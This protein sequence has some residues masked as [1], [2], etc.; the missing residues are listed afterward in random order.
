MSRLRFNYLCHV[1]ERCDNPRPALAPSALP[2]PLLS[3]RARRW[4]DVRI[5]LHHFSN[6]DAMLAVEDHL[7]CMHVA[8]TVHLSQS[9]AGRTV[10]KQVSPGYVT[11]APRGEP[12]RLKHAGESAVIFVRLN[13][14]Y[15]ARVAGRADCVVDPARCAL[16]DNCGNR[17]PIA[18][19]IGK[20]M[21]AALELE[22]V[23]GRLRIDALKGELALHLLSHYSAS[24]PPAERTEARLSPRKLA[25]AAEYIDAHLRE[26]LSLACL[27][28]TLAMSP[29]HLSHA[30]RT[31]TGLPPH[32]FVL[33]RRVERAKHLL[34]HTDLSITDIAHRIGCAS[35]SHFSV[36]FRRSTGQTP[37]DFRR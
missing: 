16:I 24:S 22:D 29:S 19:D 35:H 1:V 14:A 8:G 26:D 23:V 30:F 17:D 33:Q 20:R 36:L 12:K 32:R 6:L 15:V 25:R 2:P 5:E 37:R 34:R 27:A 13:P 4:D 31:A 21:L 3:S 28:R 10:V 7:V 18:V 9:R 11:V